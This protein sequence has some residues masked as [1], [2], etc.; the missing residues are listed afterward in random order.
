M[1]FQIFITLTIMY[2]IIVIFFILFCMSHHHALPVP[3]LLSGH[4]LI[5]NLSPSVMPAMESEEEVGLTDLMGG[6]QTSLPNTWESKP[7]YRYPYYD[8]KGRGYLLY[9]YGGRELYS[10]EEFDTL[11]GFY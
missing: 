11:E 3:H 2:L 1:S 9:G 5:P 10:Y 4:G 7:K 8:H 6:E